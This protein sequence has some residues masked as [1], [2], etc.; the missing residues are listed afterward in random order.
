MTGNI[1]TLKHTQR[2]LCQ[3][4]EHEGPFRRANCLYKRSL[5]ALVWTND[6][7]E[8]SVLQNDYAGQISY[9]LRSLPALVW[10]KDACECSVLQNDY[11]RH[12]SYV[13]ILHEIKRI[14]R[15]LKY[16]FRAYSQ[17]SFL[18]SAF[19][20]RQLCHISAASRH[21]TRETF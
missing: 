16:I 8:C 7:C 18:A 20:R 5:P 1:V 9:V 14:F 3:L 21:E 15:T 10:T 11:A 6:A 17:E 2:K 4:G 19:Q 12:I 13:L